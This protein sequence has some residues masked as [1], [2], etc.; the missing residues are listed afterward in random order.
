VNYRQFGNTDLIVSEIGLGCQSLGGGL[1][2]RDDGMALRTLWR[3]FEAG[4]TFYD[5]SDHYSV[6]HSEELIGR[7]F[8][9]RRDRVI[10]SSKAGTR[11][12]RT[13]RL[14]LHMRPVLR[15]VSG[16]LRPLKLTFGR[17][18]SRQRQSDFSPQYLRHCVEHSLRRLKTD[19]LDLFQLHKPPP[20][21]LREAA[22]LPTLE[23]LRT[24]GKIRHY[25]VACD[26]V[27]DALSCL[28]MT[29]IAS[30]QVTLNLLDQEAIPRVLPLAKQRN[31]AV[32]ARNPRGQ[33]HLT[34]EFADILAEDYAHDRAAFEEIQHRA[35]KFCF[36]EKEN[37]TLTQAALQFVRQLAGVSVV[38][39]RAINK[40]QLDEILGTLECPPLS[41]DELTAISTLSSQMA[42]PIRRYRY[43]T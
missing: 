16:L 17:L 21:I 7:A 18:R 29:G 24:Q 15:P 28:T 4:I 2:H 33:G 38:I 19:Y 31:C 40:S 8:S 30:I 42:K 6:G 9:S 26:T 27:D 37:R 11:Y 39:P 22:F 3:A 13:A 25:G 32:I 41:P 36:L 10:I 5:T 1:Y 20:D 14:A 35:R 43:R 34:R 12:T 23:S